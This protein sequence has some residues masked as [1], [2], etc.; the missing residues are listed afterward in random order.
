MLAERL[1]TAN[2]WCRAGH[3][4]LSCFP[5]SLFTTLLLVAGHTSVLPRQ[6]QF[7]QKPGT[8]RFRRKSVRMRQLRRIL[9][10]GRRNAINPP[11]TC[12]ETPRGSKTLIKSAESLRGENQHPAYANPTE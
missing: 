8:A 3:A 12:L 1:R 5:V 4:P 2:P 6:R 7:V 10:S 9:L 11:K